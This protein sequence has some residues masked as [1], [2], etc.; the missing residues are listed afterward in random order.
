MRIKLGERNVRCIFTRSPTPSP[1][2]E[3]TAPVAATAD[4]APAAAPGSAPPAPPISAA[5]AAASAQAVDLFR[6]WLATRRAAD[7]ADAAARAAADAEDAPVG[8]E[9]PPYTGTA[10]PRVDYGKALLPVEGEAMA[11]FAA[12]GKRIPRRGEIGMTPSDIEKYEAAGFVMSGA[13]HAR[14]NA[15]RIRK[16]NQVYSAEEKAAL[17]LYSAEEAARREAAVLA[18]LKRLVSRALGDGGGG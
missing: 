1:E 18:D 6:A 15:I 7:A 9:A 8:P 4:G 3:D 5:E 12:A 10:P 2:P 16:E 13:R 11:A 17:A 14:I